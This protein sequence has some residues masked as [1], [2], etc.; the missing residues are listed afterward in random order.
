MIEVKLYGGPFD[1]MV[2]EVRDQLVG[3]IDGPEEG[4][5]AY[6]RGGGGNRGTPRPYFWHT[7]EEM[8]Y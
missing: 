1:G 7:E 3:K 6:Y 5:G 4:D 8:G 2:V